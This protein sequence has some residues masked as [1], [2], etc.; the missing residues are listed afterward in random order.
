[1]NPTR[2]SPTCKLRWVQRDSG[3]ILQ[4]Q[5]EV[6]TVIKREILYVS[7]PNYIETHYEWRDVPMVEGEA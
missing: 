5:F 6:T 4:Q 2:S 7:D 1:M 3:K